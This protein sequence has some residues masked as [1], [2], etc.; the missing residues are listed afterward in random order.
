M[1]LHSSQK[2]RTFKRYSMKTGHP[3]STDA[4]SAPRLITTRA[5]WSHTSASN[6]SPPLR[7]SRPLRLLQRRRLPN[8]HASP[9]RPRSRIPPS[10]MTNI[11]SCARVTGNARAL[12]VARIPQTLVTKTRVCTTTMTTRPVSASAANVQWSTDQHD[13]TRY[14]TCTRVDAPHKS[15][16]TDS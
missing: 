6:V 16:T 9:R 14:S 1:Q 5:G 3:A 15:H 7:R 10:H 8:A 12:S 11:R 2:L 4:R 13:Q